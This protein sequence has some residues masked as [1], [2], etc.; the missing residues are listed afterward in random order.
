MPKFHV[1]AGA[2]ILI[3][4]ADETR[5]NNKC[6]LAHGIGTEDITTFQPVAL[7]KEFAYLLQEGTANWSGFSA[8]DPPT[9][10]RQ[11]ASVIG[12]NA[13]RHHVLV[14]PCG[15]LVGG[16]ANLFETIQSAFDVGLT[17]AGVA[18]AGSQFKLSDTG[19]WDGVV[20]HASQGAHPIQLNA[21]LQIT[22]TNTPGDQNLCVQTDEGNSEPFNLFTLNAGGGIAPGLQSAIN[23]LA[24]YADAPVTVTG[25]L[26]SAVVSTV[27]VWSGVLTLAFSGGVAV[28][29]PLIAGGAIESVVITGGDSGNYTI[30]GAGD[31]NLGA[32]GGTVQA[33]I[34]LLGG[35][36]SSAGVN[37][38]SAA[39]VASAQTVTFTNVPSPV[40]AAVKATG[41]AAL[42]DVAD[43][44]SNAD[45]IAA[46]EGNAGYTPATVSAAGAI[47]LADGVL[48]GTI[49]LT[50]SAGALPVLQVVTGVIDNVTASAAISIDGVTVTPGDAIATIQANLRA[51]GG[52]DA[53]VYVAGESVPPSDPTLTLSG[54]GGGAAAMNGVYN[55]NGTAFDNGSYAIQFSTT[56]GQWGMVGEGGD[57][58]AITNWAS[59]PEAGDTNPD[60]S[61]LDG[62]SWSGGHSEFPGGTGPTNTVYSAGSG[63]AL[64]INLLY[65][66]AAG[67][68]APTVTVGTLTQLAP[69]G[70]GLANAAASQTT[71]GAAGSG[72]YR[73]NFPPG[74][75]PAAA[76]ATG[77]GAVATTPTAPGAV[78]TPLVIQQGGENTAEIYNL[79]T[80][81]AIDA[82]V[83]SGAL[84]EDVEPTPGLVARAH[85]ISV[86]GTTP[87]LVI[88]VQHAD[89][90]GD[91]APNLS[92]LAT[93]TT[94]AEFTVPGVLTIRVPASTLKRWRRCSYTIGGTNPAFV[95]CVAVATF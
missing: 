63:A 62:T 61:T 39:P 12:A 40:W 86:S 67:T 38:A 81:S 3:D 80:A 51:A 68:Y 35:N 30:D 31:F 23:G 15:L 94:F 24:A 33:L 95:F 57:V 26:T 34:R 56:Y 70:T 77:T 6:N 28:E 1:G 10:T 85:V 19:I 88:E 60:A 5:F 22:F 42:S 11:M 16:E 18:T 2:G 93:V 36:Y 46:I 74:L 52:S 21:T 91:G 45:W 59:Q 54:G 50:F 48:N 44:T 17:L 92:T 69:N 41:N 49:T 58:N 25:A 13:N 84:P 29:T 83:D 65:P 43:P 7:A 37:G 75:T 66:T 27:T 90:N 89:D 82:W 71:A 72:F 14:A 8:L 53:E 9:L 76:T 4:A 87:T 47:T 78:A 32:S 79:I 55:W 73:V 20:L 64:N